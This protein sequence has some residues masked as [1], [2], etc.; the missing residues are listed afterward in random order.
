MTT[1]CKMSS[2]LPGARGRSGE[3]GGVAG[4]MYDCKARER[5]GGDGSGRG[6]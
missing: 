4:G 3:S 5:R 1:D 2:R 6:L